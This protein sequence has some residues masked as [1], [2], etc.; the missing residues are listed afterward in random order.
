MQSRA[1]GLSLA[2]W[3]PHLPLLVPW[4]LGLGQ[5]GSAPLAPRQKSQQCCHSVLWQQ[6][7]ILGL[8]QGRNLH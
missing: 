2:G 3:D 5:V 8:R 6:G 7:L 1:Q 4:S